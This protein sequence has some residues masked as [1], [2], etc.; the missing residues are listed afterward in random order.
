L[1]HAIPSGDPDQILDRALTLLLRDLLRQKAAVT[2]RPRAAA[3]HGQQP[4]GMLRGTRHIPAHVKRAV[5]ARDGGQCA[6]RSEAGHRCEEH[7]LVEFHH[8][9]PEGVGGE[10][11]E[12]NVE[13]RCRAHNR[14]EAVV[15]YG[16]EVLEKATRSGASRPRPAALAV[17]SPGS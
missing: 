2:Q 15:F 11:S 16:R 7:G 6:F 4:R 8:V 1:R 3:E 12:W 9:D 17:A 10:A 14:Y 13:L 5:W